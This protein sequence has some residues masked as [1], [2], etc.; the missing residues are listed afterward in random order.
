[1]LFSGFNILANMI[2]T[3]GTKYKQYKMMMIISLVLMF[4]YCLPIF[5]LNSK[6]ATN[7]TICDAI[8]PYATSICQNNKKL[9]NIWFIMAIFFICFRMIGIMFAFNA[10]VIIK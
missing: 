4:S 8:T 1:M 3:R 6:I 10:F 9:Y 2:I 5:E 7:N